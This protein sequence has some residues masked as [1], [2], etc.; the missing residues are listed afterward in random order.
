MGIPERRVSCRRHLYQKRMAV[1]GKKGCCV[2]RF[3]CHYVKMRIE[4]GNTVSIR[5]ARRWI[6]VVLSCYIKRSKSCHHNTMLEQFVFVARSSLAYPDMMCAISEREILLKLRFLLQVFHS[7]TEFSFI[8][9]KKN[10][11]HDS[12]INLRRFIAIETKAVFDNYVHTT[13]F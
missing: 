4:T 13:C 11:V 6:F 8:A 1:R 7:R 10:R 9:R 2:S 5:I 3:V 12:E